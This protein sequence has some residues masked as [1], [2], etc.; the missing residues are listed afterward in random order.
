[1]LIG[2]VL[3]K[4]KAEAAWQLCADRLADWVR[5]VWLD[6]TKHKSQ[7]WEETISEEPAAL[8]GLREEGFAGLVGLD[9]IFK[10]WGSND[11]EGLGGE[12]DVIWKIAGDSDEESISCYR[13]WIKLAERDFTLGI[14][15]TEP[16]R[17]EA[18][19]EAFRSAF[20]QWR[21]LFQQQSTKEPLP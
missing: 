3:E 17:R 4:T 9:Y 1:M 7:K 12:L 8:P 16:A 19:R 11:S 5:N 21:K 2:S 18:N 15:K 10:W 20:E 6:H 14:Y 13:S